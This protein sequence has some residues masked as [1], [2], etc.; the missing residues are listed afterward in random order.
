M[1]SSR[2]RRIVLAA[3][4]V[5]LVIVLE[6]LNYRIVG[7]LVDLIS[8][9]VWTVLATLLIVGFFAGRRVERVVDHVTYGAKASK[10]D[11]ANVRRRRRV[12]YVPASPRGKGAVD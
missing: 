6:S 11:R 1:T 12:R 5:L 10:A 2:R 3:V 8:M 4:G 7:S 9:S